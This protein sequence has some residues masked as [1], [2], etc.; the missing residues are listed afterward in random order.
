MD[1][2][3][4]KDEVRHVNALYIMSLLLYFPIFVLYFLF[5][6]FLSHYIRIYFVIRKQMTNQT[7]EFI[8]EFRRLVER[9][10]DSDE[11]SSTVDESKMGQ[12]TDEGEIVF[13]FKNQD[14]QQHVKLSLDSRVYQQVLESDGLLLLDV[15]NS[16][17]IYLCEKDE[18]KTKVT[19]H[20]KRTNAYSL[21][22]KLNETNPTCVR[23][24]LDIIVN[25]VTTI[26]NALVKAHCINDSQFR[27][28]C[29]PR[30]RV[31]MDYLF[32]LPD[33][34]QVSPFVYFSPTIS[35]IIILIEKETISTHHGL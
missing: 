14:E 21:I 22:E 11:D 32:F 33:L 23:E 31:R 3:L 19:A 5:Q 24:H 6:I 20:M 4:R 35:F 10:H 16:N 25:Q 30:S 34:R 17:A 26:L 28:M 9:I 7:Y 27:Q 2:F 8:K 18:M 13:A 15:Y 12:L 29:I 1:S